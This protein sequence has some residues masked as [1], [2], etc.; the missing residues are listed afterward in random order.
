MP[1]WPR[2]GPR[3][4]AAAGTGRL[5]PRPP[6][7]PKPCAPFARAGKAPAQGLGPGSSH[8]GVMTPHFCFP[9]PSSSRPPGWPFPASPFAPGPSQ[10]RSPAPQALQSDGFPPPSSNFC[11]GEGERSRA[12]S[13]R[14]SPLPSP[15]QPAPS[16]A[17]GC[18]AGQG[19]NGAT[20]NPNPIL[21]HQHDFPWLRRL[22]RQRTGSPLPT[23]QPPLRVAL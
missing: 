8:S 14:A 18:S 3:H 15:G 7:C 20:V 1:T 4:H 22:S 13:Q 11:T 23:T 19:H 2:P 6:A 12:P 21:S 10:H 16:I 9:V 5:Q 17:Q